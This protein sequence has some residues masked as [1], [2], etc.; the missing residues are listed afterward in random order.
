MSVAI[1]PCR[2]CPLRDGCEQREVFRKKVGGLGLVSARFRCDRL[3][4]EV[5][6]GRRIVIQQPI[7]GAD[8]GDRYYPTTYRD[9][10]ATISAVDPRYRFSCIVDPGQINADEV[11]N[12][13]KLD[14]YRFRKRMSH[15]RIRA[16]LDEPD[17]VFCE[18]GNLRR[19]DG[20]DRLD[21]DCMCAEVAK[22]KDI[23]A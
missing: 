20:C 1:H 14:R 4:A 5:R 8:N 15:Q 3:A 13:D 11:S 6:M 16:F 2:G 7:P 22:W 18:Q 17:G 12:P 9:V 21:S 10:K 19:G 23:A